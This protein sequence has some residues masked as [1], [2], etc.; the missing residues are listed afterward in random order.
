MAIPMI[1]APYFLIEFLHYRY[2]SMLL[3]VGCSK[4]LGGKRYLGCRW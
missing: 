1:Q 4:Y 3:V 2:F